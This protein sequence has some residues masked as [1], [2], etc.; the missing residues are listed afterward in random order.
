MHLCDT[1]SACIRRFQVP[2]TKSTI[3]LADVNDFMRLVEKVFLGVEMHPS[4]ERSS[5][6]FWSLPHREFRGQGSIW[7]H[8]PVVTDCTREPGVDRPSFAK[9]L[10]RAH[11]PDAGAEGFALHSEIMV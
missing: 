5:S 11:S 6:T 9:A 7:L 8:T 4:S 1:A 3:G 10:V 2:G